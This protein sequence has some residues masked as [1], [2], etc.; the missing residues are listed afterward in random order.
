MLFNFIYV[1]VMSFSY[2]YELDYIWGDFH[3]G[4]TGKRQ[5]Q[6]TIKTTYSKQFC[7]GNT[8]TNR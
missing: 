5:K 1:M 4:S 8:T 3:P 7:V 2:E 6:I